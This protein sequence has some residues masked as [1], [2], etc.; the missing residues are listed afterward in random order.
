MKKPV[1]IGLLPTS[2]G[3]ASKKHLLRT[4][5]EHVGNP[6]DEE[7]GLALIRLWAYLLPPRPF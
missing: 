4:W 2:T 6:K 3:G 1:L 7:T 5:V